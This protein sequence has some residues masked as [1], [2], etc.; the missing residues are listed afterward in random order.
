[1]EQEEACAKLQAG[2]ELEKGDL[3]GL[4]TT[5]EQLIHHTGYNIN[6]ELVLRIFTSALPN[7]MYDVTTGTGL[8]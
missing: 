8:V 3:D 5:F 4:L 2:L 1:M 6:H 7:A